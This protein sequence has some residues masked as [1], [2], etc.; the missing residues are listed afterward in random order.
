[1]DWHH[2]HKNCPDNGRMN[3]KKGGGGGNDLKLKHKVVPFTVQQIQ[4]ILVNPWKDGCGSE[5]REEESV[6]KELKLL[7][8][9]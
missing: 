3:S 7:T 9:L 6:E 4:G 8:F 2:L 1:M 5:L